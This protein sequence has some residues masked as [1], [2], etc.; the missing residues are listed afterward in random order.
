M[1]NA[2]PMKTTSPH[3]EPSTASGPAVTPSPP[4]KP[5]VPQTPGRLVTDAP[6]RMFHWLFALSFVGA[7][8]SADSEHWRLVHVALGYTLAGLLVWRG[9]Y[10][11]VG[12]RPAQ[13]STLWRKVS[14]TRAWLQTVAKTFRA[15]TPAPWRQGQSLLMGLALVGL[16]WAVI[17]LTLTG[18]ATFHEWGDVLGGDVFEDLHE[19][20]GDAY[21]TGVL[22]HLALL[23]WLSFTRRKN[24]ALPMLTGRIPGPGP[25]LIQNE[26]RWLA[27]LVLASVLAYWVWEV[28][29][30]WAMVSG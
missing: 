3:P 23:A 10:G 16:L 25:D 28:V 5:V 18:Y 22:V 24:Q 2:L 29:N 20:L 8:I 6:M 27:A 21:L 9:V 26:R 12:P 4:A 1:M 14:G 15:G 13:L 7:Y 11:L 17:P 30:R 19:F